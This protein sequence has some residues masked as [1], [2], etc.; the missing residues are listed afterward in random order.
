MKLIVAADRNWAIG[1]NNDLLVRIPEDMKRFR[2][3][4]TDNVIVMG[5]HTLESFPN[6]RPL[7]D[8]VNIVMSRREN[9]SVKNA[10]T[11]KNVEELDKVLED[12]KERE[13]YVVGGESIYRLLLDRCDEAIVTEIDFAY[14][15]DRF[16]PN[17]ADDTDW[18][19]TERSEEQTYYDLVFHYVTYKRK[20]KN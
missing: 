9:Y 8:R 13:V 17:L 1:K 18:E 16:F 11:V 12:Y 19:E 3:F 14:D 6:G 2:A 5:R 7:Q 15:A 4:T 20:N 10:I